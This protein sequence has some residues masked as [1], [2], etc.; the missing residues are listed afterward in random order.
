M[1][2]SEHDLN[3]VCCQY[4]LSMSV[5]SSIPK[6]VYEALAMMFAVLARL[7]PS[8]AASCCLCIC[9]V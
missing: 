9:A 1:L 7:H 6:E 4:S 5:G 8:Y 2:H 3:V